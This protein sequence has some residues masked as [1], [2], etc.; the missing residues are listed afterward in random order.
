[1]YNLGEIRLISPSLFYLAEKE[2][3]RP[4]LHMSQITIW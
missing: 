1:M 3:T 4:G 2:F